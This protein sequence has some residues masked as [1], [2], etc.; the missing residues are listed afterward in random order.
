VD[1]ATSL[2]LELK[3]RRLTGKFLLKRAM[4]DRLPRE[5]VARRKHGFAM[6]VA[7]WLATELKELTRDMLSADRLQRQGLFDATYVNALIDDHLA[8]RRD[9]RKPLW[10]LLM[11]QL[12][13]AKYLE[14][15]PAVHG[16]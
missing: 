11:F 3:L 1:F 6:P 14:G 13:Y 15:M 9:N 5:I 2:P 12:W 8:R 7:H 4:A 10:T 16:R